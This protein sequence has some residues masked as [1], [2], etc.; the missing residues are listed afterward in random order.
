MFDRQFDARLDRRSEL[1]K[2][3]GEVGQEADLQ[4]FVGDGRGGLFLLLILLLTGGRCRRRA[5]LL[6][7]LLLRSAITACCCCCCRGSSSPQAANR[8][9]AQCAAS[10][11]RP[12]MSHTSVSIHELDLRSSPTFIAIP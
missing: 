4:R 11:P 7:V 6:L 10:N 5:L 2:R 9:K 8:P 3:S 1:R 12:M